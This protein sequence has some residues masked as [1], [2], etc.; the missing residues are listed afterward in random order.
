[1]NNDIP[2]VTCA[3]S[4]FNAEKTIEY[5]LQSALDQ[6]YK[7]K[8]LIIV[9]DFS[10][11]LTI[12]I[13]EEVNKTISEKIKI[14]KNKTNK[15]IGE[16]RNQL[17]NYSNG[18]FIVFFDDDDYSFP[19]RINEQIKSIIDFENKY[20]S[21]N[22]ISALCY[23]NRKIIYSN[24]KTLNCNSIFYDVNI[25]PNKEGALALLS[26]G[27][28]DK[29][30]ISGST[31]TCTLCSRKST[32]IKIGG[33]NKNLKRYED[34][35]LAINA[36]IKNISLISVDKILI[37]Q[38]YRTSEYKNN[39]ELFELKL[40]ENHKSFLNKYNLF[41]FAYNYSVMKNSL[42]KNRIKVFY[43]S[44]LY[45]LKK[46]PFKLISKLINSFNTIIFTIFNN[47]YINKN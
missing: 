10:Q 45:L 43:K 7:K 30:S 22:I 47:R 44:F 2:L 37:N 9:D 13:I 8:E 33:F 19:D 28:I 27:E 31:A 32:L 17:I 42:L 38:F 5:A 36:L 16:V 40:I 15:G 23:S 46:H 11:D 14:Y 1:M 29:N 25:S 4:A 39:A 12:K 24:K 35:D 26:A 3:F 6:T 41:S 20:K 21:D 34:L 18:E